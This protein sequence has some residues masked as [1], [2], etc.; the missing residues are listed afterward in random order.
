MKYKIFLLVLLLMLCCTASCGMAAYNE[1][2]PVFETMEV[3][4]IQNI[5]YYDTNNNEVFTVNASDPKGSV[6]LELVNNGNISVNCTG[7]YLVLVIG[8]NAKQ[9]YVMYPVDNNNSE[10][11]NPGQ[12]RNISIGPL[13]GDF[14]GYGFLAGFEDIFDTG[15]VKME[16]CRYGTDEQKLIS[17][18]SII[19]KLKPQRGQQKPSFIFY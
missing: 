3:L 18:G 19:L 12:T 14:A 1:K 8:N 17:M 11:I 13:S 4:A 5:S 9:E 6:E 7:E 16:V 10:V 2:I 15:Y